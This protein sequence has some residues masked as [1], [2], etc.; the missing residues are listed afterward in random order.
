MF[1]M[2]IISDAE[3]DTHQNQIE[4]PVAVRRL[5]G[6][7][8]HHSLPTVHRWIVYVE[9]YSQY[10]VHERVIPFE[11]TIDPDFLLFH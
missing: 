5:V 10:I 8:Y 11:R 1:D 3:S 4:A 2:L 6:K 9:V 7:V